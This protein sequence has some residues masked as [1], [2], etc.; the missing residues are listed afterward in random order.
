MAPKL[1]LSRK[2][3]WC[4]WKWA[5]EVCRHVTLTPSQAHEQLGTVALDSREG[6][7]ATVSILHESDSDR[8]WVPAQ[9]QRMSPTLLCNWFSANKLNV[10]NK[11]ARDFSGTLRCQNVFLWD[12][13]IKATRKPS[14]NCILKDISLIL[15]TAQK[16]PGEIYFQNETHCSI[17]TKPGE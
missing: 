16:W 7:Y 9:W 11:A 1:P 3:W 2:L 15:R 14:E 13:V 4:T 8:K 5:T 12:A 10:C 17:Q 6:R